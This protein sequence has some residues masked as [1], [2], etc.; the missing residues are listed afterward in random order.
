MKNPLLIVLALF[1]VWYLFFR[2]SEVSYGPGVLAPEIPI[3]ENDNLIGKFSFNGYQIK[4][5]AQFQLT[6]KVL[7]REN[8]SSGREADLSPTDLAF[9]WG[10][11]SDES[12]LSQLS[13][14][15]SGR[16][17]RWKPISNSYPIPRREIETSSANM[18]LIPK[19]ESVQY[20]LDNVRQ[21]DIVSLSGYLVRVDASDGWHWVSSQ[22]RGDTGAG[23]CELIF[24]ES[25]DIRS[26]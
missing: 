10:R 4:P 21:G 11:M 1:A 19:N 26:Y 20:D 24:V 3:Q 23:A 22:T 17:Y 12:V 6:A 7:S 9:G 18:H 5:L 8:Y 15:Q 2:T 13:I 16:W 14:S 25:L